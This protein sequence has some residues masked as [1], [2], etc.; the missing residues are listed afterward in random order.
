[1]EILREIPEIA[2]FIDRINPVLRQQ[3]YTNA[4]GMRGLAHPFGMHIGNYDTSQG[5]DQLEAMIRNR[6]RDKERKEEKGQRLSNREE[7]V[8]D[9][10]I[11]TQQNIYLLREE[12]LSKVKKL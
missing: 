2:N 6:S 5:E 11:R 3:A 7:L 8:R 1:M 12:Y 4:G 10:L 9:N